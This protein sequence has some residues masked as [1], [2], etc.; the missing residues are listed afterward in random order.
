MRLKKMFRHPLFISISVFFT[1]AFLSTIFAK[2]PFFAFWGGVERGDGLFNWL[3]FLVFLVITVTIFGKKDWFIFFK[4]S[5]VVGFLVMFYGWLQRFRVENFPF[6]LPFG[7]L[8][9]GSTIGNRAFWGTYI[10]FLIGFSVLIFLES[11]KS[12]INADKKLIDAD[13]KWRRFWRYLSVLV[14]VIS[15]PAIA[16][17]HVRGTMLGLIAGVLFGLLYFSFKR[18]RINTDEER[19]YTDTIQFKK[20]SRGALI[21]LVAFGIMFAVTKNA[22][23]W[24]WVPGFDRLATISLDDS[25]LITRKI[26]LGVGWEAFKEKPILGWG[27]DNYITA[28]NTYYNPAYSAY[29]EAFFDRAHSKPAEVLVMQGLL[30][31]LSYLT[32]FVIFFYVLFRKVSSN[33]LKVVLG[34]V[35]IAY[36]VQNL[37]LFDTPVSH[38]MLFSVFGFLISISGGEITQPKGTVIPSAGS[39]IGLKL[40]AI[41][42]ALGSLYVIYVYNYRPFVQAG[43]FRKA[44]KTTIGSVIVEAAPRFLEPYNFIQPTIRFQFLQSVVNGG[45]A[46]KEEF[47]PLA[48][49]AIKSLQEVVD[50]TP[51]YDIRD[52]SL[53]A[54]AYNDIGNF[55][56]SV[57]PEAERLLRYAIEIAPNRQ[58]TYYLLAFN[59]A[60]QNRFDESIELNRYAISLDEG[61]AK[62][63]YNLG[64]SLTLAG[65][66][67]WDEAAD[68]FR[69]ALDIGFINPK[70]LVTDFGNI[71]LSLEAMLSEYILDRDK[72][73]TIRA[74]GILKEV[75]PWTRPELVSDMDVI[76]DYAERED[77]DTLIEA[78]M[79]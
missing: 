15:V 58:D 74:A 26:A 29:E 65:K 68:E 41:V 35:I 71:S 60:A 16:I 2:Y 48:D 40:T 75:A 66:E 55:D 27:L 20:W 72:E 49:L 28:Y 47:R 53:I 7:G 51:G 42:V 64:I 31:L 45:T 37:V 11:K 8:H 22:A 1:S 63:H 62:S 34:G 59:M 25:S 70:L 36:F 4:V 14:I 10:L 3:H 21:V 46:R 32:V 57:L 6:A 76:I 23:I 79:E 9:G 78:I 17:A 54:E 33:W 69:R 77:W 61:V 38:L 24:Q 30:G 12:L 52:I 19:I 73:R 39:K 44:E 5:L 56:A 67:Y 13:D 50:R 18:A 43:E